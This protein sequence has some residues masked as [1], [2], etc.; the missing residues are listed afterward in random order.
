MDQK[1]RTTISRA[2]IIKRGFQP[3][4]ITQSQ[5]VLTSLGVIEK[6]YTNIG[7]TLKQFT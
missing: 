5:E 7:G 6:S 4:K 3:S 2:E 1:G